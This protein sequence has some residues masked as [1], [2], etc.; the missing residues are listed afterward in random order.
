[1]RGCKHLSSFSDA[2]VDPDAP[3]LNVN[4]PLNVCPIARIIPAFQHH[5]V[6]TSTVRGLGIRGAYHRWM[7]G[8][9]WPNLL[10]AMA[11]CAMLCEYSGVDFK[12]KN[13]TRTKN[14][15]TQACKFTPPLRDKSY[16]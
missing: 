13:G 5:H 7:N 1:M 4:E 2:V 12:N 14:W 8:R 9:A 6:F 15:H 10:C 3:L 16:G 11:D